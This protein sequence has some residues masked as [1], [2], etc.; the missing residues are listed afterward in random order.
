MGRRHLPTA[1]Q[2]AASRER[3]KERRA[4][5]VASNVQDLENLKKYDDAARA[6]DP[7]NNFKQL[8][9]WPT[10]INSEFEELNKKDYGTKYIRVQA[11]IG[12]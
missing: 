8:E 3:S 11:S 7:F 9:A 6:T 5:A 1:E 4:K 2:Q 12:C 10:K